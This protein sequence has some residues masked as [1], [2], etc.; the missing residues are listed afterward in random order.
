MDMN[1]LFNLNYFTL[2]IV[3]HYGTELVHSILSTMVLD[4][5]KNGC[6]FKMVHYIMGVGDFGQIVQYSYRLSNH[7]NLLFSAFVLSPNN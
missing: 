1:Y 6:L 4:N 5:T 3:V 7:I 2:V